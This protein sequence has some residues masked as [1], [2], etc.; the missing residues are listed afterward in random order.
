MCVNFVVSGLHSF[1]GDIHHPWLL[2]TL[3]TSSSHRSLSLEVRVD[4]DIT[5]RA[6]CS[7]V[8]HCLHM[9]TLTLVF[10]PVVVSI[11]VLQATWLLTKG[12]IS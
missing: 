9:S 4:K 5:F 8:S 10:I 11:I 7:T 2:H 3:F 12:L 6:D 1:L